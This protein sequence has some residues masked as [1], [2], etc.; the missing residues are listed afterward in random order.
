MLAMQKRCEGC[1]RGASSHWPQKKTDCCQFFRNVG[2]SFTGSNDDATQSPAPDA[3]HA[4]ID[5]TA[6]AT[7]S[8]AAAAATSSAARRERILKD[9]MID[10]LRPPSHC[11]HCKIT[12]SF[13]LKFGWR[14]AFVMLP[15]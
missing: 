10:C 3:M 9:T 1:A 4:S 14:N 8:D 5:A 15:R 2:E 11:W 6:V 13:T 7:R 12:A